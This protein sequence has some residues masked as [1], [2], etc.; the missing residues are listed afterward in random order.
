MDESKQK[1]HYYSVT[2]IDTFTY[3]DF[4]GTII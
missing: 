1:K 3:G 2:T 4:N